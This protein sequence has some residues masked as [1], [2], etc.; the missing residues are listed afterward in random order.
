MVS[1]ASLWQELV[2]SQFVAGIG[3]LKVETPH[4]N[5]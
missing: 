2:G 1:I 4:N 3:K 5:F